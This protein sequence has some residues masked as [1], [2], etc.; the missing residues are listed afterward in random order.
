[1][2]ESVLIVDDDP[3]LSDLYRLELEDEGYRVRTAAGGREAL[4]RLAEEPA[5]LVVLDIKM[6]GMDG[7]ETLGEL[8][9]LRRETAVVINS[10]YPTFKT[11]FGSWNA[12]AYVVKSANLEELKSK[13]REVLDR[14]R[15]KRAA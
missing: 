14:K 13:V 12:D 10:A 6:E 9:R 7:L 11:D 8:M 2:N 3:S 4:T 1:M 5:D 15:K